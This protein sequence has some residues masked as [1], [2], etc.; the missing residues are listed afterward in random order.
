[1]GGRGGRWVVGRCLPELRLK[2]QQLQVIQNHVILMRNVLDAV[3]WR[4]L[5]C[6]GA[7]YCTAAIGLDLRDP[8]ILSSPAK[9]LTKKR[10][11][12]KSKLVN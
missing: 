8:L 7:E 9:R 11:S 1:M 3:E 5:R 6:V 12:S 2:Q 4:D 10:V